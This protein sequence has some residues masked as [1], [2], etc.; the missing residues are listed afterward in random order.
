MIYPGRDRKQDL[1]VVLAEILGDLCID[2]MPADIYVKAEYSRE[3]FLVAMN[4][5]REP[6]EDTEFL[7][8][9]TAYEYVDALLRDVRLFG[10]QL[11]RSSIQARG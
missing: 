1:S 7:D 5:P 3:Q 2:P 6:G 10:I 4:W 8:V 11:V 9:D